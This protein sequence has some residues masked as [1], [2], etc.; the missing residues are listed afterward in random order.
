MKIQ[1]TITIA[2][3]AFFVL[4]QSFTPAFLPV[5]KALAADPI[6]TKIEVFPFA[7]EIATGTSLQ[8]S[9]TLY[10]EN[11][12]A[13]SV[14]P[15]FVWTSSDPAVA[16]V[17]AFGLVTGMSAGTTTITSTAD[18]LSGSST[19]TVSDT[20][21][22]PIL[23]YI[24][25]STLSA[26]ATVGASFQLT[27]TA[28]DQNDSVLADQPV[29]GWETSDPALATVDGSGLVSPLATGTVTITAT[30]GSVSGSRTFAIA[31]A[32]PALSFITVS[33]DNASST[34]GTG[35]Q[36][37]ATAF[38][39]NSAPL[40]P[41]P[42]FAWSSS[43]PAVATISQSGLLV[44]QSVGSVTVTASSGTVLGTTTLTVASLPNPPDVNPPAVGF[45]SPAGFA[46]GQSLERSVFAV[47]TGFNI[48]PTT[49]NGQTFLLSDSSGN[50]I[51]PAAVL[52]LDNH[53]AAFI[54]AA[55]LTAS[56][57][58]TA[59][60]TTGILNLAGNPMLAPFTWTF[61]TSLNG[62]AASTTV[63]AT[64]PA[65]DSTGFPVDRSV[66]VFFNNLM[67]PATINANSFRLEDSLGNAISAS[68]G[69]QG[70]QEFS[71]TPL[72]SLLPD[73]QYTATIASSASDAAGNPLSAP[74]VWTFTTGNAVN[75][76]PVIAPIPALNATV[77]Q[78]FSF[79]VPASDP[80]GDPL[81]FSLANAPAGLS[82]G[83]TSGLI[84][85]TPGTAGSF[86]FAVMASDGQSSVFS[87][88]AAITVTAPVVPVTPPSTSSGGGGG[89][90]N[91]PTPPPDSVSAVDVPLTVGPGQTGSL[92]M[93]L[94]TDKTV[95]LTVPKGAVS[96]ITTFSIE[97]A[98]TDSGNTPEK[99]STRFIVGNKVF[100]IS[101]VN[102]AGQ[103]VT[104]FAE[105][106]SVAVSTV[107]PADTRD[108]AVYYFN[109]TVRVWTL[110]S[111]AEFDQALGQATFGINHLTLFAIFN[112]PGKPETIRTAV[113]VLGETGIADGVLVRGSKGK[114]YLI[115]RGKRVY[116]RSL[117]E[118]RW[119]AGQKI[120]AVDDATLNLIPLSGESISSL[121]FK[122]GNLVRGAD[123]KIYF[124]KDNKRWHIKS[125]KEL[126]A[127]KGKKIYNY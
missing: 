108:L 3:A 104:S 38:D 21:V 86:S 118:L 58:Y 106:L 9:T 74:F 66:Q 2:L 27:A 102:A 99:S 48:D 112:A 18:S 39:Q 50:A 83:S 57:T 34:L 79:Q 107:L 117:A 26:T 42:V 103:A 25:V 77:G 87:P 101:A 70:N 92:T 120:F 51:A 100:R 11:H 16:T 14:Q 23:S 97:S 4:A 7:P 12:I 75:R 123:K 124:L 68:I 53:E 63:E 45:V 60:L 49:V 114:T 8:M 35:V 98:V 10:D 113:Q 121:G 17:D 126:H 69:S 95:M 28:T 31:A 94:D 127:Y 1:K 19:L 122:N 105:N 73:T 15:S 72:I 116:I 71:L 6:P 90:S 110:V 125:L 20:P 55:P 78:S 65:A 67:D 115:S 29:F 40:D 61:S 81:A 80:N 88:D 47:F 5:R 89:G 93:V 33:P 85:W 56:T 109:E 44:P 52:S 62:Q 84:S 54:L 36:F 96:G 46:D 41:Q 119:F 13:F 76:H 22:T 30:S 32:T 24:R 82:I 43:D 37:S 111:G 91:Y 59:T 64:V